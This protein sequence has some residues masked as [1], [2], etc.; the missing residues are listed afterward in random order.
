MML[1]MAKDLTLLLKEGDGHS[2]SRNEVQKLGQ[3]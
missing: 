3:Q 1:G 2:F